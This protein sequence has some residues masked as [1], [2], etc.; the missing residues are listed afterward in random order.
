METI[1]ISNSVRVIITTTDPWNWAQHEN[2]K[3]RV[4]FIAYIAGNNYSRLDSI[5]RKLRN[6]LRR[7]AK[8]FKEQFKY[9]LKIRGCSWKE[10]MKYAHS[11]PGFN[12]MELP[13]NPR[14]NPSE[15]KE[16]MICDSCNKTKADIFVENRIMCYECVDKELQQERE[17]KGYGNKIKN[18]DNKNTDW[19]FGCKHDKS[20]PNSALRSLID[21]LP[22]NQL[23]S[24]AEWFGIKADEIKIF[25]YG[26]F[27]DSLIN[28]GASEETV[29][30]VL[31]IKH[32]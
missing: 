28:C 4:K 5:A 30:E 9:E 22:P 14:L 23:A 7:P 32:Q 1:N 13:K 26:L 19:T 31:L 11:T 8:Q 27:I 20:T 29:R 25:N 12:Y 16:N 18:P 15:V 21:E 24:I 2:D 17:E 6:C 3:G 10:L